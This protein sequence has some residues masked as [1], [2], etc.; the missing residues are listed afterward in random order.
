MQ[1]TIQTNIAKNNYRSLDNLRGIVGAVIRQNLHP[2][3][4][5]EV[6]PRH[7]GSVVYLTGNGAMLRDLVEALDREGF[8][9]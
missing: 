4:A 5:A 1:H 9:D 8:L 2:D 6:E 7:S 3:H